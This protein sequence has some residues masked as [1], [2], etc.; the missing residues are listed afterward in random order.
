MRKIKRIIN[1]A[2]NEAVDE[3]LNECGLDNE[4]DA[5]DEILIN[6]ETGQEYVDVPPRVA[7]KYLNVSKD[8]I[9]DGLKQG[10]LPFGSAVQGAGGKWV[11]NIP[12]ERLKS[13]A[14]GI[15]VQAAELINLLRVRTIK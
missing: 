5:S 2:I 1:E 4:Q 10:R 9:Y 13:Y 6:P 11:F 7:A 12:V 15:D 14:Y 3:I 8:F